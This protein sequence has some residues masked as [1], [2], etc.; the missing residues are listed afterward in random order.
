MGSIKFLFRK[1]RLLERRKQDKP[2]DVDRRKPKNVRESDDHFRDM[3]ERL[4]EA[5]KP[6]KREIANDIQQVVVFKTFSEICRFRSSD[7]LKV[8]LCRN[9]R[10]EEAANTALAKC[11]E[12]R[13]PLLLEA[14]KGAA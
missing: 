8:R 5:T 14:I 6:L 3:L 13:C 10:H 12:D 11:D 2:V 9:P 4:N 1:V 7:A